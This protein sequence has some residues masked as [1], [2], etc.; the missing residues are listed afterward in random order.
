[1]A[2]L[3]YNIATPLVADL[4]DEVPEIERMLVMVQ[5]EVAQ[6]LVAGPG[7]K[8][9]GAVSVKVAYWAEASLVGT[10][11]S[12][13]FVP[14]P[15]VGSALVSLKRRRAPAGRPG[16]RRSRRT[17]Q[18]CADRVRTA[19]EN[20]S[21][22]ARGPGHPAR[23]LRPG[24]G[25]RGVEGGGAVCCR[26]GPPC[27]GCRR[28]P[29]GS[30]VRKEGASGPLVAE[31]TAPA[32]LTLS[33]RVTG[34][35]PD[36]YHLLD[37]EMVALDLADT[38]YFSDGD[39][40]EVVDA[41]ASA[42]GHGEVPTDGSNLVNKA[43]SLVGRKAHVRLVKRIPAGAGL[44]GG[45]ADAA[46]VLRWAG[47]SGTCRVG[48]GS[49][50]RLRRPLLLRRWRQGKGARDRSDP[51]ASARCKTSP[52]SPTHCWCR[53]SASPRRPFTRLGT[54]SVGRSPTISTTSSRRLSG[55]SRVWPA[56]VTNLQT[57]QDNVRSSQVAVRHGSFLA[58]TPGRAGLSSGFCGVRAEG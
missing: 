57:R 2:N 25:Q 50:A 3:P 48:N 29:P 19:A 1:M 55:W 53:P 33:L 31:V 15:R 16:R 27:R 7:S 21:S 54:T 46:A 12:S 14:R 28:G 5:Q 43:L 35:R 37:A 56:G 52:M 38:L 20:A 36:G 10:V 45:S 51:R 6:R 40:L 9:Y 18:P 47:A 42:G 17:V 44:G 24:R 41:G 58:R 26:L 49:R 23:S 32:K 4:L 34:V 8:A 39:G 30:V 22:R 11:P 13:V